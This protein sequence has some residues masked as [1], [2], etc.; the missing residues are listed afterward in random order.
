MEPEGL[1]PHPQEPATCPCLSQ[2]NPVHASSHYLKIHLNIILPST[3]GSSKWSL[4]SGFP[5]KT[6]YTPLLYLIRVTCSAHLKILYLITRTILGEV[7]R[8][9]SSSLCSLLYSYVTSSLL[10]PYILLRTLFSNTL[11]VRLSLNISDQTYTPIQS[12][13]QNYSSEYLNLG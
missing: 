1:L 12:N 10:G 3:S 9:I 8:S 11:S 6:L 7:Y 4:P 5:T 13:R 2:I